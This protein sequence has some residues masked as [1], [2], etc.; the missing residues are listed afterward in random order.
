[1]SPALSVAAS[2]SSDIRQDIGIQVKR[3][4]VNPLIEQVNRA[5]IVQAVGNQPECDF[6]SQK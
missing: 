1:M 2:L 4:R 6:F 3:P 5:D